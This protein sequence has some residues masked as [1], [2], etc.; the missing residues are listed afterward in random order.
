M[1]RRPAT[2]CVLALVVL[3][4]RLAAGQDPPQ[5]FRAESELVVLHVNVF[6]E[7]SDAVP[8]L[9][10]E[11][12]SVVEDGQPQ[13]ITFFSSEDVPVA[14]G[15]IVDNSGSMIARHR[16]VRSGGMAFVTASHPEDELFTISFNSDIQFG[17]PEGMPFTNI[18][19]LLHAALV[20]FPAG[21]KTALYDAVIAGLDHVERATHQKHVLVV[22][23]DGEDNAS[24]HSRDEMYERVRRSD[25]IIYTV[26]NADRRVGYVGDPTVL[27][28]LAELGGG[29]AYFPRDEEDVIASL[30]EVA[31]NIRRGYSIGYAPSNTG[32]PGS[33]RRVAVNVRAPGRGK[34]TVRSR[35]GYFMAHSAAAAQ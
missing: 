17:L 20:R 18:Q 22:L 4:I 32:A 15:L 6:D 25:A 34:L 26:S 14:A 27:K 30:G 11:A 10:Q 13:Q 1:R 33:F 28:K 2:F 16:M 23:S 35:N 9:P 7:R 31:A 3:A 5:V 21:G 24:R 29:V 8:E 19:P 12:F